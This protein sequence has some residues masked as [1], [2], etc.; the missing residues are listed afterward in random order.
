[1]PQSPASRAKVRAA[2]ISIASNTTLVGAKA[3]VALLTGSISILSEALHSGNDLVAALM[4][5][6]AVRAATQP[7]DE[8]HRFG[9][10]KFESLSGTIEGLLVVAVSVMIVWKAGPAL[11][12]GHRFQVNALGMGV[13]G[14][15]AVVNLAVSRYLYRVARRTHSLALE[16]DALHLSTDV[17]T[18][19]AVVAGLAAVRV[20]HLYLID[21]LLA[22]GVAVLIAYQAAHLIRR[23]LSDLVDASLPRD[24]RA[25]I[26]K[27]LRDHQAMGFTFH[28]LRSRR[29]GASRDVDLHLELPPSMTIEAA[30]DVCDHLEEEIGDIL[31]GSRVLIHVEPASAGG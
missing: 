15:S 21:P 12:D 13:M 27:V 4:A 23:G 1:M 2:V 26:E 18:S 7:P 10:G 14:G 28:E 16:A 22:L 8:I 29:S 25:R 3:I 20:T 31:P 11:V 24:E 9:H 19:A 30:H 5:F 6:F 17:Y